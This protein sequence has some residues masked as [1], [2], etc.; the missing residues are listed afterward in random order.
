[1]TSRKMKKKSVSSPTAEWR[2]RASASREGVAG[3]TWS[4]TQ[5]DVS[6]V[7]LARWA[8]QPRVVGVALEAVEKRPVTMASHD[9]V[10]FTTFVSYL[11]VPL[12]LCGF[13]HTGRGEF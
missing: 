10:N 13:F 11:F 12:L 7:F 5:G 1:M 6:D 8:R 9:N 4:N 3:L 2:Q